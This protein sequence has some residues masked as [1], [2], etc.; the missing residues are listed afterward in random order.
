MHLVCFAPAESPQNA[1]EAILEI[2]ITAI[3]GLTGEEAARRIEQEGYNELPTGRRRGLL[4]VALEV[5][6][7]PMFLLLIAA[8]TLYLLLG[9]LE[10]ALMLL[11]FVFVIMGITFYQERKTEHALEALR[12]LSSPRAQ[13]IRDGGVRRIAGREVV[14]GDILVISEGDRVPADAVLLSCIN[15]TVDE[16]LLTGESIAVTKCSGE[17]ETEMARP[18]GEDLPFIYSGTL[19]TQG[20]G[21]ATVLT[22]GRDT[23]MGR[24][25]KALEAVEPEET[26]LQ[27]E[28]RR[29]VR[30]LA[31]LGLSLCL[32]V[33]V[34]Y[35]AVRGDWL[36]GLLAGIALA[37]ATLPEEFP[38]V[39]TVF[40]ALGAWRISRSQVLTRRTPA[41]ET[42]GAATTLCVDKTGTLTMNEMSV[43]RLFADGAFLDLRGEHEAGLQIPD[44]FHELIEYGI[45]A[46]QKDP[47]DPMEKAIRSLGEHELARTEHLHDNWALVHSYP[48]SKSLLALSHVW[49]SSTG[50][51]FV[52]A[53]KGA[54]EAIA[55]LC[56]FDERLCF[57]LQKS[58]AGMAE[59][60][61]RVLG[62][63]RA[64][65]VR[66]DLPEEQH[67]F[68]FE[69]IGLLGLSDPLRATVPKAIE[70][71]YSAGVRVIMITGD[72]PGTAMNIARQ[73]GLDGAD[74]AI[75]GPELDRMDDDELAARIGGVNIFARV[76][77]EQKLR[78]VRALQANGEVV[79]MTGDGVNDSPALKA[80]NIGIAMGGRGTDVA[81]EASALV[82]LDDDFS[83]I[84]R[85]VRLGRRIY[86]NIRKAM[87]YIF[88]VHVPIVG[89]SLIPVLLD[90]PLVLLPVHI[91]FLELI[92]DPA[93]SVVFEAEPEEADVMDRPPRDPHE[94]LFGRRTLT[95]SILQ[96]VSVLIVAM[97]V[98]A[99]SYYR[100]YGE[101][102]IRASVFT[103]LIIANVGLIFTNRSWSRIVLSTLRSPNRALWWLVGSVFIV[104][105]LVLYVPF[106]NR[107]FLF[108]RL[109]LVTMIACS[110]AGFI[111]VAW[112]E[113]LKYFRGRQA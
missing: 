10:E 25:G 19:V 43:A 110:L 7:E 12:D 53:T 30:N 6:R 77:P 74:I 106:L 42:L 2:D 61:L 14:R 16:S 82:L 5:V 67:D 18:G 83:S 80:A 58:I 81:R 105:G 75:T 97:S 54:P 47:F 59:E 24:I 15:L 90:W 76:V 39:L 50:E 94:P 65:L 108:E 70:E 1:G 41:I 23:E 71:C 40:L 33:A 22:I 46:S 26:R 38:V 62:V 4:N 72:Y 8:G 95:L 31:I 63:A 111:S 44:Q 78:L 35:G 56:H 57:E 69:F 52:I 79:A 34:L 28:T 113:L 107:L 29:L 109:S 27:R 68:E 93:C 32:M 103:T 36:G 64:R 98:F 100:G 60:G 13:V 84:V 20:S 9:D 21:I 92:I 51:A 101:G 87:A 112:F 49:Q 85:A 91:V 89:L 96:G 73:I 86:D 99:F 48:L 55:D 11:M 88:A 3:S 37:M 17:G 45:L 104:L 102:T 66:A